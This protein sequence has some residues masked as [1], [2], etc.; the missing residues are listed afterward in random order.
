[1]APQYGSYI[2]LLRDSVAIHRVVQKNCESSRAS[3]ATPVGKL[4]SK[5][6]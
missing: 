4:R 1:M 3:T 6:K 2:R 5:G